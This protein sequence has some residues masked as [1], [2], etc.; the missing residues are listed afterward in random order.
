MNVKPY[1]I[2]FCG[3]PICQDLLNTDRY[4]EVY[5]W[6]KKDAPAYC[7]AR[8]LT[9][10]LLEDPK[11]YNFLPHLT[12]LPDDCFRGLFLK[13]T[14]I[15]PDNI[16]GIGKRCFADCICLEGIKL[17]LSIKYISNYAFQNCEKLEVIYY[18]GTIDEWRKISK[19][20][21]WIVN[22]KD[23]DVIVECLDGS[24]VA[25]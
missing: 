22:N 18:Q 12:F 9:K 21:Y 3:N 25:N 13:G 8:D 17:P 5:E 7:L 2:D 24:L 11:S 23:I 19:S 15:V 10:Y 6:L 4:A 20:P 14:F 16:V 1:L